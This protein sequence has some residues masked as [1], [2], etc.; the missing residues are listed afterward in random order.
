M[1]CILYTGEVNALREEVVGEATYCGVAQRL[2]KDSVYK[3][4]KNFVPQPYEQWKPKRDDA[5]CPDPQPLELYD[6]ASDPCELA[7]QGPEKAD[8]AMQ[9]E[10]KLTSA[11][12]AMMREDED[13]FR[14]KMWQRMWTTNL[15]F[16]R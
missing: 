2:L 15:L 13:P 7:N 4:I 11:I 8:V 3:L 5:I 12:A 10:E 1:N 6:I 14:E 9:M 16:N